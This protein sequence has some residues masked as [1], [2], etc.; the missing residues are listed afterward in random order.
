M[1]E[2]KVDHAKE[3]MNALNL[4]VDVSQPGDAARFAITHALLA[5]VEQQTETQLSIDAGVLCLDKLVE[6]LKRVADA[7]E[8]GNHAACRHNR[9]LNC[10]QCVPE[11]MKP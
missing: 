4:G 3:A 2:G 10:G 8:D 11:V 9:G 6:Q 7:M 1:S 5:L